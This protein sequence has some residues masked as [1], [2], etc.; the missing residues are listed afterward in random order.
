MVMRSGEMYLPLQSR[1]TEQ[2]SVL[3][4][5]PDPL[6]QLYNVISPL[7]RKIPSTMSR[8]LDIESALS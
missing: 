6:V 3:P 8:P 5:S 2:P 1:Y 4:R 7:Q